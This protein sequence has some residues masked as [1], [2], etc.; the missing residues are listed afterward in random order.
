MLKLKEGCCSRSRGF[1][2]MVGRGRVANKGGFTSPVNGP[3]RRR[4]AAE[5]LLIGAGAGLTPPKAMDELL[6]LEQG[7]QQL[8]YRL[9]MDKWRYASCS[10]SPRI[11]NYSCNNWGNIYTEKS[12]GTH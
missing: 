6:V 12:V 8:R 11:E 9:T 2:S 4:L 5:Q 7:Q 1:D 10:S 3:V